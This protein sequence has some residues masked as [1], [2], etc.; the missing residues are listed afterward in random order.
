MARG[1][2]LLTLLGAF[3]FGAIVTI[4]AAEHWHTNCVSHG[5]VHG[6][7]T[8]DGSFFARVD[9]G[10]GSTLRTCDLYTWGSFIGGQAV[11]GT[12]ATCSAWSEYYGSY[13][14]CASTAHVYSRG[15]FNEHI[16]KAHNW[17]G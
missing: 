9:P 11:S 8:T 3:S 1:L 12:T 6:S 5:F 7:S 10:C 14:E 17:C 4:A 13:T 15:V 2:V 16:H